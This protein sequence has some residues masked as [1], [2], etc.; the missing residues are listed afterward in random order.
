[1]NPHRACRVA[2]PMTTYVTYGNGPPKLSLVPLALKHSLEILD[3]QH[4]RQNILILGAY[5][6]LQ[7]RLHCSRSIKL[8]YL[9]HCLRLRLLFWEK[10]AYLLKYHEI[11]SFFY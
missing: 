4:R 6:P 10:A 5:A 11:I 7:H 1:M 9:G 3:W 2:H 8:V